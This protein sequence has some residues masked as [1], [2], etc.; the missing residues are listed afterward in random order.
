MN[1]S[2][3]VKCTRFDVPIRVEVP[4][5]IE[6]SQ[7]NGAQSGPGEMFQMDYLP[8]FLSLGARLVSE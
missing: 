2:L 3:Q 7:V 8:Q 4:F 5:A 6:V 1:P